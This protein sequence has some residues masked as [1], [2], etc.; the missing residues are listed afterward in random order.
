ML[1]GLVD[2]DIILDFDLVVRPMWRTMSRASWLG[3]CCIGGSANI[4]KKTIG[5]HGKVRDGSLNTTY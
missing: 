4:N 1:F 5:Q 2:E 3:R